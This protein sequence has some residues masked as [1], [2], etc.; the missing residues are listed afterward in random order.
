MS[1]VAGS[2]R[3][4]LHA[5][6][7]LEDE[8]NRT[9]YYLRHIHCASNTNEKMFFTKSFF[10]YLCTHTI[11]LSQHVGFRLFVLEQIATVKKM[12]RNRDYA[13]HPYM[14]SILTA[15]ANVEKIIRETPIKGAF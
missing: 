15:I 3:H 8:I 9:I 12:A 6:F 1:T 7:A 11:R 4:V 10:E 14:K 13:I 5:R 2:S